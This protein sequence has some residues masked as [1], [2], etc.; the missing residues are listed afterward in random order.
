MNCSEFDSLWC[1]DDRHDRDQVI[2]HAQ[3]CEPCAAQLRFELQLQSAA[4]SLRPKAPDLFPAIYANLQQQSLIGS[5]PARARSIHWLIPLAAGFLIA[6][7]LFRSFDRTPT[8]ED[9]APAV[10]LSQSDWEDSRRHEAELLKS[11]QALEQQIRPA[12]E[13]A[14]PA[15]PLAEEV[16]FLDVAIAECE[17]ALQVNPRHRHL[18]EQ[19]LDLQAKRNT[20]LSR[21][22]EGV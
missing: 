13:P 18:R 22:V 12:R 21:L 19:L 6:I 4:R 3:S 8:L 16:H 5:A 20:I 2:R 11:Q 10:L 9:H 1:S 17:L 15:T 7:T 14:I